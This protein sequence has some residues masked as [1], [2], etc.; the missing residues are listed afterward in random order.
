MNL[1]MIFREHDL[2]KEL[3]IVSDGSVK[4][5][6]MTYG[7]VLAN[8]KTEK[9]LARGSGAGCGGSGSLLCAE[10][11]GMLAANVFLQLACRFTN[12]SDFV[13]VVNIA[14]NK[15]LID[16]CTDHLQYND[17]YPNAVLDTE[18]D[19]TKEAYWEATKLPIQAIF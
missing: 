3:W 15:T 10:A 8:P 4:E 6:S 14:D 18:Q 9:I 1:E 19:A 17:L 13:R 11:F 5:Q 7:W 12:R 16:R 2:S